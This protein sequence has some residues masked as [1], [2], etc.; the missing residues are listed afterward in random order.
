LPDGAARRT[1]G[2]HH[3]ENPMRIDVRT[4]LVASVASLLATAAS[5]F[6][7]QYSIQNGDTTFSFEVANFDQQWT[8]T[9][10][11]GDVYRGRAFDSAKFN[12]TFGMSFSDQSDITLNDA[13]VEATLKGKVAP[14]CSGGARI[15]LKDTT[16]RIS[17]TLVEPF[18]A[19][20]NRTCEAL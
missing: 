3:E 10:P 19:G 16:H 12:G 8:L 11:N 15:T 2:P 18:D 7:T 4:V 1:L 17:F 9:A 13:P 6:M 20:V 14:D 5:A